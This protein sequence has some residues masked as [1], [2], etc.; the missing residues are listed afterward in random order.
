MQLLKRSSVH[1]CV[2]TIINALVTQVPQASVT[3]NFFLGHTPGE[4]AD[5]I[6]GYLT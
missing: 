6:T 2:S 5:K 1:H 3:D 4:K